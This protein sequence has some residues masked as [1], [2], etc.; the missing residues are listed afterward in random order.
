MKVRIFYD[1]ASINA[2]LNGIVN[3]HQTNKAPL[4]DDGNDETTP[5]GYYTVLLNR[6][7]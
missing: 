3:P 5:L 1:P 4:N 6:E 7:F 2:G